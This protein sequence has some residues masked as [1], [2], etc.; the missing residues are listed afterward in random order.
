VKNIPNLL[1]LTNLFCGCLA[2]IFL[3]EEQPKFVLFSLTACLLL[4]FLDGQAA[5]MLR[6]QNRIGKQLDSLADVISFGFVPGLIFFKLIS[7]S[8]VAQDVLWLPILGF[9]FTLSAALRLAKF[10][11]TESDTGHFLG[12]PTPAATIFAAGLLWVSSLPT[13]ASCTEAFLHAY[14]LIFS[15]LF[16]SAAMLSNIPM[17]DLKIR[18][19]KWKGNEVRWCYLLVSSALFV[20]LREV[21]LILAIVIYIF[22][23]LL[24]YSL[25]ISPKD[26]IPR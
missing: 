25:N 2:A 23:S 15:L 8:S 18:S 13:C 11:V 10:N 22:L 4:D 17:F 16:L 6:I 20:W 26:E 24:L 1:T 3:I 9:V 5:R 21:G 12:L 14:S 19:L 7:Q